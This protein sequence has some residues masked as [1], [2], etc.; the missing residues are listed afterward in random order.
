MRRK[1]GPND[2]TH[3][4]VRDQK[5]QSAHFAS[6]LTVVKLERGSCRCI[7]GGMINPRSVRLAMPLS[8]APQ[9]QAA[10]HEGGQRRA[11][12][13]ASTLRRRESDRCATSGPSAKTSIGKVSP[14]VLMSLRLR[15]SGDEEVR[16]S[17]PLF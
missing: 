3:T 10:R 7:D 11:A 17:D 4:V 2:D 16:S 8:G 15:P 14:P 13:G 6:A 12:M 9:V 5:P 1:I